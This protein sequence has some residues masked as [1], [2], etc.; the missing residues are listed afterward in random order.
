VIKLAVTLP[1][2]DNRVAMSLKQHSIKFSIGMSV[3]LTSV[4]FVPVAFAT[5]GGDPLILDTQTGIHDGSGGTV[6]QTGP[7]TEHRMV[8]APSVAGAPPQE[9]TVIEV[10]PYVGMQQGGGQGGT[11]PPGKPGSPHRHPHAT[12]PPSGVPP[13]ITTAP[14][15]PPPHSTGSSITTGTSTMRPQ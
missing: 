7:L 4:A 10:S 12:P 14:T 2:F 9:Q 8:Q 3:C 15:S 13:I 1:S 11:R 5:P 6:L